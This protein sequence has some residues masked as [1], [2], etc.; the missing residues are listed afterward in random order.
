MEWKRE[1]LAKSLCWG[2][3]TSFDTASSLSQGTSTPMIGQEMTPT[4]KWLGGVSCISNRY[5]DKNKAQ[6]LEIQLDVWCD[7]STQKPSVNGCTLEP[8]LKL[9]RVG[10]LIILAPKRRMSKVDE[11]AQF[12]KRHLLVRETELHVFWQNHLSSSVPGLVIV[13]H[14]FRVF[15]HC[16]YCFWP[17]LR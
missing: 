13:T 9:S 4:N 11:G 16:F 10:T 15:L 1:V 8:S 17:V 14:D 2:K 5:S 3:I 6:L 7:D 12:W